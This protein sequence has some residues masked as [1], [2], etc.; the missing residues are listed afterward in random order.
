MTPLLEQAFE[1]VRDLPGPEQDTIATIILEELA[2]EERW[3]EAFAKSQDKLAEL[4]R[5]ARAD[6][7][8]RKVRPARP[9][10]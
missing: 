9:V 6:V 2:D 1:K 7:A 3:D 8:G 5:K 10:S 4:A